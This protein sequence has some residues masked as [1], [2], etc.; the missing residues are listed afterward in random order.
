MERTHGKQWYTRYVYI[1]LEGQQLQQCTL[2]VVGTT[3]TT[4]TPTPKRVPLYWYLL[5]CTRYEV[6]SLSEVVL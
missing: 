3:Y 6:W 4:A 5:Q 1:H 2:P